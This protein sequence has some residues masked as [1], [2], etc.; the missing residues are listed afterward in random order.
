MDAGLTWIAGAGAGFTVSSVEPVMLPTVAETVEVPA[1][2][3]V[4]RPVLLIVATP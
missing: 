4:A 1:P 3:V 2:T